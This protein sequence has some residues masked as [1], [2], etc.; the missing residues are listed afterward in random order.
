MSKILEGSQLL[1]K[2]GVVQ[3][4]LSGNCHHLGAHLDQSVGLRKI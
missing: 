2:M 1:G 3:S 4:K